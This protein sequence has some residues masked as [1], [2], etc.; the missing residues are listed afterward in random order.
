VFIAYLAGT[1]ASAWAGAAASQYGR[2]PVLLGSVVVMGVGVVITLSHNVFTVL[3]GL[4]V[5]TAGFFG[6]HATASG[7]TG[8]LAAVGKAQAGSLYNLAYYAGS[9]VIGWVGG[10]AFD[11]AGWS[12]VAAVIVTL[13]IVAGL[14]AV[15]VLRD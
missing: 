2:R 9:S 14:A 4:L 11:A 5:A 12:A 6:A 13:E 8:Q 10:I 1:W 3:A 15:A 7:W